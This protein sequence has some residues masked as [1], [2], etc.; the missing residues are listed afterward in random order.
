MATRKRRLKRALEV[1]GVA[2]RSRLLRV[3]RV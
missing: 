3:L 2:R 1:A